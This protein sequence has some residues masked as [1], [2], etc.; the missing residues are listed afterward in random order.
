MKTYK[1]M[2]RRILQET[3]K[4]L[5]A[6]GKFNLEHHSAE[7]ARRDRD[8]ANARADRIINRFRKFGTNVKTIDGNH[9]PIVQ[10]T[11]S[12]KPDIYGK[13]I[14]FGPDTSEAYEDGID[15]EEQMLENV[16]KELVKTLIDE[17]IV[18]FYAMPSYYNDHLTD[19]GMYGVKLYVIPWDQMPSKNIFEM[20]Q[21]AK[22]I[23]E[24][25]VNE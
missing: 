4:R 14:M 6:E 11:Y 21:L 20:R 19:Q 8:E 5:F 1:W 22:N 25:L 16:T 12:I 7:R 3:K 13:R 10:L 23:S 17:N 18:K 9:G 24:E 2:Q 15:F